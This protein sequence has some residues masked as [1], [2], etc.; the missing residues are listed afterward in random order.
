[1][2]KTLS[3]GFGKNENNRN[4]LNQSMASGLASVKSSVEDDNDGQFHNE[5]I[6]ELE[7]EIVDL[8]EIIRTGSTEKE[9]VTKFIN[10]LKQKDILLAKKT[11]KLEQ[12]QKQA[13]INKNDTRELEQELRS[14]GTN[15]NMSF[16][17]KSGRFDS[18]DLQS[19]NRDG[20]NR[21]QLEAAQE[22]LKRAYEEVERVTAQN[23]EL[24]HQLQTLQMMQAKILEDSDKTRTLLKLVLKG[25]LNGNITQEDCQR[26]G[27][28]ADE[29]R[30]HIRQLKN[31]EQ[32]SDLAF[33]KIEESVKVAA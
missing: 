30:E 31:A 3:K 23:D 4:E 10:Q 21:E 28:T 29:I 14:V 13:G 19:A 1:M 17:G 27:M 8:R 20:V 18:V 7:A 9:L 12:I 16:K 15:R 22:K 33:K 26:L 2:L 24:K 11:E 5:R 32:T 25:A 6:K